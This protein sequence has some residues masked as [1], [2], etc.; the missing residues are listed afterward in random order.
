[1]PDLVYE[2]LDLIAS[3]VRFLGMAVAGVAL[4]WLGL[5]LIRKATVWQ[6]QVIVYLGLLGIVIALTCFTAW[7]ALGAF[8]L[9]LGAALLVWGLLRKEKMAEEQ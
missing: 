3:L 4:G 5:D 2:I 6:A 8:C 7:G 9:G 1:M